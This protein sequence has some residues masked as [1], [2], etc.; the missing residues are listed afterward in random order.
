MTNSNKPLN[1]EDVPIHE[2]KTCCVCCDD[3]GNCAFADCHCHVCSR[4]AACSKPVPTPPAKEGWEIEA[5][6]LAKTYADASYLVSE[7][8]HDISE[9]ATALKALI[10]FI[11]TEI[12]AAKKEE[13]ERNKEII[14]NMWWYDPEQA[15]GMDNT[16]A[17]IRHNHS[18]KSILSKIDA[19]QETGNE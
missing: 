17:G 8:N 16:P 15:D 10:T 11:R 5:V 14:K 19:P 1:N 9:E 6:Y 12:A 3:D 18:I 7:E 2:R 4:H 13:R